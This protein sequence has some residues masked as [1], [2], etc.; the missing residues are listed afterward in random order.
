MRKLSLIIALALIVSIG[1]V[2][3]TWN[4]AQ[5]EVG[6]QSAYI[7]ETHLTDKVV[8]TAKGNLAIDV[9]AVRISIDDANND[10]T[11]ELGITGDITV[12]FTPSAGADADVITNGIPV[13]FQLSKTANWTHA[14]QEIFDVNNDWH[15]LTMTKQGD[16]F[17][18]TIEASALE[19][20][21][22]LHAPVVLP[23]SDSYDLFKT[24]IHGGSLGVT[25]AEGTVTP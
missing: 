5:G 17:V 3:A 22:D 18:G 6:N 20:Y 12:T 9:S 4:Y 25:V 8:S 2:Y 19:G 13:K 15:Q 10:H 7:T 24:S 21:I 11:G 1:G 14:E 23:T 16:I